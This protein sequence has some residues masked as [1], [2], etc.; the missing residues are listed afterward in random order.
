MAIIIVAVAAA[1]LYQSNNRTVVFPFHVQVGYQGP[2]QVSWTSYRSGPPNQIST[3]QYSGTVDNSRVISVQMSFNVF[4]QYG[5]SLCAQ[6]T[7]LDNSS[8]TL[9]LALYEGNGSFV[10][11]SSVVNSTSLPYG[12]AVVC[13]GLYP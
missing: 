4:T 5:V 3:G 9:T 13:R 1:D 8:A 12:S 2:W 10:P 6:A 7:K 11:P